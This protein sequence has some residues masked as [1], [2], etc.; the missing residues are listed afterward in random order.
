MEEILAAR[1]VRKLFAN[2]CRK[3]HSYITHS[4]R[5]VAQNDRSTLQVDIEKKK[6]LP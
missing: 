5:N 3:C 2:E 1:S 6:R 4:A